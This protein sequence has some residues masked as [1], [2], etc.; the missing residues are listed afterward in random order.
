MDKDME[1]FLKKAE[2]LIEAL[3][4]IREFNRKIILYGSNDLADRISYSWF[5]VFFLCLTDK[6]IQVLPNLLDDIKPEF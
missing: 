1:K 3:P 5:I 2:V 6:I 4:Y